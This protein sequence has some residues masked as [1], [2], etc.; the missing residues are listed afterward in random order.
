MIA[1]VRV[2]PSACKTSQSIAI[3]FSPNAARSIHARRDRPI[4][5]LISWVR[6]PRRPRTD[7][8]SDRVW[9]AA[10]NIAYSAVNQPFPLP[11]RQRGTPMVTLAVHITRV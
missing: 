2:P 7:S 9:V 1:A 3:V 10:G 4:S 11:F 5:L 8:R 6:P